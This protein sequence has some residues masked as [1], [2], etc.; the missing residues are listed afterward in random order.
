MV[1][2][3]ASDIIF[4]EGFCRKRFGSSYRLGLLLLRQEIRDGN[5]HG[6]VRLRF[7]GRLA[8]IEAL[9]ETKMLD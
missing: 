3:E 7:I 9:S 2:P 1:K 6:F 4:A 8:Q 5:G